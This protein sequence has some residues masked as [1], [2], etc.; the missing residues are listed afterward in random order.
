MRPVVLCFKADTARF[1]CRSSPAS[2]FRDALG[3]RGYGRLWYVGYGGYGWSSFASG[4]NVRFLDFNSD[5]LVPQNNIDRA[6]GFPLRCLQEEVRPIG[7]L[8]GVLSARF[9]RPT[10]L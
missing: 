6:Y 5:R 2:G 8:T 7:C 10:G 4:G 1:G 3:D 9:S